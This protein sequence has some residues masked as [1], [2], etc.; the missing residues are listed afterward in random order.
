M[1]EQVRVSDLPVA[2]GVTTLDAVVGNVSGRTSQIPVGLLALTGEGYAVLDGG[3]AF[4]GTQQVTG[5]VNVLGSV[6][7]SNITASGAASVRGAVSLA[8]SLTVGYTASVSGPASFATTV[9]IGGPLTLAGGISLASNVSIGGSASVGGAISGASTASFAGAVSIGSALTAAST[10][11]VTGAVG[12]ASTLTVAGA[13]SFAST[14]SVT[15]AVALA[16]N[17][18]VGNTAT[19]AGTVNM[20]TALTVGGTASVT[21]AVGFAST[22]TIGGALSAASTAS[23]TGAVSLASSVT[24]AGTAS[25]GGAV[26][27]A[28]S[29]TAGNTVSGTAFIPTG[30]T[31]PANG[32][33][34]PAANTVGIAGNSALIASFV[35]V[36]SASRNFIFTNSN[37]GNPTIDV[38]AGSL[39]ITPAVVLA[40]TLT[41]ADG[42]T[43]G[44][45]GLADAASYST[46]S[47]AFVSLTPTWSF[48]ATSNGIQPIA[49]IP[50]LAPTGASAGAIQG[51]AIRAA[52]GTSA[53][54]MNT[55]RALSVGVITSAGYTGVLS[56]AA[57]IR[58]ENLVN[59]G[60]N[61]VSTNFGIV[62]DAITNGNGI[63][64]G[65]VSNYGVFVTPATA[66]AAA[67]GTI[68]NRSLYTG[69][70]SGSGA[71]TTTNYGLYLTGNG[72]SGGGGTTTNYAL[73]SDSTA[74]SVFA[75]EVLLGGLSGAQSLRVPVVA[76][77]TRWAVISGSNGGN[78]TIDVS[79]GSLAITPATVFAAG[80]TLIGGAQFLT[81]SS[82]LTDYAAAQVA[83]MTNGPVAGNPTKW[84]AINDNGTLR[85]IP[86]W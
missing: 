75:G 19:F 69:V 17:L 13:V 43:W 44:T 60:T 15:G 24:V 10:A 25:I 18:R 63:T 33:Y 71:G 46:S 80:I 59:G 48:S 50:V 45:T 49:I 79:A 64:T 39:A 32:I 66:S 73:Y 22:L 74:Q 3:N 5:N 61:T 14:A 78:P 42:A 16:S 6:T 47:T 36:A 81:T 8:S 68:V 27:V 53:V 21:G 76:S 12:F 38:S 30:S 40:N 82:A 29:L 20:A 55:L 62:L 65:T 54:N 51:T 4:T 41:L 86:A 31:I 70:P 56:N 57:A 9:T 52:L 2:T 72:G 28:T 85:K 37:G 34:L 11:S 83:T 35:G 23:V 77:A 7:A 58:V 1:D 84:I 26:G 67:G